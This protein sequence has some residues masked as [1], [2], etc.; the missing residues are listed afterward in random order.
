MNEIDLR[1]RLIDGLILV[2]GLLIFLALVSWM[3]QKDLNDA[4]EFQKE[5]AQRYAHMLAQC[6]NG[7]ILYD[8]RSDRLYACDKVLEINLNK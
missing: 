5:T 8:K 7:K 1:Y 2:I 6:M 4:L 3:Q